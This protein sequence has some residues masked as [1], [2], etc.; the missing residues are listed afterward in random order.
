MA[1]RYQWFLFYPS[2]NCILFPYASMALGSAGNVSCFY[3]A[4]IGFWRQTDIPFA[5]SV[6]ALPNIDRTVNIRSRLGY[7]P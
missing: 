1:H 2:D 4:I 6:N 5:S 7:W 3:S